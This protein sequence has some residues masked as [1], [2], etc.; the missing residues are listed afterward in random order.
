[1]FKEHFSLKNKIGIALAIFGI[2]MVAVS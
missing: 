2:L 1:L